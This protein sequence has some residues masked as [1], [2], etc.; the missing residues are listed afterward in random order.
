MTRLRSAFLVICALL[1]SASAVSCAAGAGR[2]HGRAASAGQRVERQG[3]GLPQAHAGARLRAGPQSDIG[4]AGAQG[5]QRGIAGARGRIG[6]D[7]AGRAGRAG[8]D[9]SARAQARDHEHSD[10]GDHNWRSDRARSCGKPRPSGRERHGRRHRPHKFMDRQAGGTDQGNLSRRSP[11][12]LR[13]PE[14]LSSVVQAAL[15]DKVAVSFG[16]ELR[17]IDVASGDELDRALAAPRDEDCKA[18]MLLTVG[19]VIRA[20]RSQIADYALKNHIALFGGSKE[21]AEAGALMSFGVDFDDQFRILSPGRVCR[22]DPQGRETGNLALPAA[23]QVPA[24]GQPQDGGGAGRDDPA[25]D[26]GG[27]QRGDRVRP[28]KSVSAAD[29]NSTNQLFPGRRELR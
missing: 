15:W 22:Q 21:D 8:H 7:E 4:R 14:N 26:P 28:E 6:R 12:M 1:A 3:V 29:R 2:L 24:R 11:W 18:A 20:R 10:R 5:E 16:F 23:K 9:A 27:G 17:T 25:V 19:A 13:N